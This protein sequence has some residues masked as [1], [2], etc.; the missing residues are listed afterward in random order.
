MYL[1]TMRCKPWLEMTG[2]KKMQTENE[3]RVRQRFA[4]VSPTPLALHYFYKGFVIRDDLGGG[5]QIKAC[6][7]K[8]QT[9]FQDSEMRNTFDLNELNISGDVKTETKLEG[10]LSQNPEHW[11]LFVMMCL[12]R[13]N[14]TGKSLNKY[15]II[16][17]KTKISVL[18]GPPAQVPQH[19]RCQHHCAQLM[20]L[21]PGRFWEE[22][23]QGF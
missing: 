6:S 22:E 14:L 12:L 5:G 19:G 18:R 8:V 7:E 4:L 1:T 23:R 13:K 10:K 20:A 21:Y 16:C 15:L 11:M 3:L 2:V 9:V 17:T